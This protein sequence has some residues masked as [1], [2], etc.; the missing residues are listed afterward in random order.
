[1]KEKESPNRLVDSYR[2]IAP[3]IG[4]GTQLA[5]TIVF[6]F[7]VG[8]WIDEYTETQPVFIIIFTFL[9]AIVGMYNFIKT[10]TSL[11]KKK[12]NEKNS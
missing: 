9:G 8:K 3:Y 11:N 7:F 12:K 1:M 6:M 5:F 2:E 4:L 10:V